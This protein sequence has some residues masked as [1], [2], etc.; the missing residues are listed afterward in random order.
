MIIPTCHDFEDRL[1]KLLWRSRPPVSSPEGAGSPSNSVS[2]HSSHPNPFQTPTPSRYSTVFG[3]FPPTPNTALTDIPST[4]RYPDPET[5]AL[6][7][8]KN[9]RT[10]YGKRYTVSVDPDA[11]TPRPTVL[12]ACVYNGLAAALSLCK[13]FSP[14]DRRTVSDLGCRFYL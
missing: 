8:E 3:I 9:K 5:G 6:V 13:P 1:I 11:P 10:W 2:G 4:P 12:Y 14:I 7:T